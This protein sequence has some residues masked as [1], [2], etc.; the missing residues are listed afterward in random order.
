M[1]KKGLVFATAAAVIVAFV[2]GAVIY[3]QQTGQAA[4]QALQAHQA[5]LV[6][7]HSP[8]W[9]NPSAK[10][11][12]VEFFDPACGTCK[13]FYPIVKSMVD[14]SGGQ[15]RVVVRY[16][17]LHKGSDDVVRI[18]EAARLQGKYWEALERTLAEQ[19]YWAPNHVAQPELVWQAITDLGIDLDKARAAANSPEVDQVLRQDM[20][21]MATLKVDK[22]PGFFVNGQPLV[23]FGVQ[24]LKDLVERELKKA[25]AS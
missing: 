18:L 14:G 9:G 23:Q 22:T 6:R 8:F 10:V 17:P 19:A 15:V 3:R 21:D 4:A 13:V 24:Q 7:P 16:A 5:A 1:N 12:I 2:A 20:A 11:T 25:Q